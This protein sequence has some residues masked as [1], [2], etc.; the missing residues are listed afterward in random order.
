MMNA[1]VG[2]SEN[3]TGSSSATAIDDPSPGSTPT[4]VPRRQPTTTQS[5]LAGVSAPAKPS[6]R[7]PST[8]MSEPPSDDARGQRQVEH[9]VEGDVAE[10]CHGQADDERA[11]PTGGA[12]ALGDA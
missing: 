7:R 4:A 6:P 10:R 1:A 2:S 12:E 8:S 11:E 5:R 9:H 3:V